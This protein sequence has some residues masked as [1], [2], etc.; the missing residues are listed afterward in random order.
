MTLNGAGRGCNEFHVLFLVDVLFLVKSDSW[1]VG[2]FVVRP[3]AGCNID[4]FQHCKAFQGRCFLLSSS[5]SATQAAVQHKVSQPLVALCCQYGSPV[6]CNWLLCVLLCCATETTPPHTSCRNG[7]VPSRSVRAG[8]K[9]SFLRGSCAHCCMLHMLHGFLVAATARRFAGGTGMPGLIMLCCILL[10]TGHYFGS[11]RSL[12]H[13]PVFFLLQ[14]L[15]TYS[16]LEPLP[17]RAVLHECAG[18]A[19]RPMPTR[20]STLLGARRGT[21]GG[22]TVLLPLAFDRASSFIVMG[23]VW[24]KT[25]LLWGLYGGRQK[26]NTVQCDAQ[27]RSA[28]A[29]WAVKIYGIL[30][31]GASFFFIAW[32]A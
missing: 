21:N 1:T 15:D 9:I 29:C 26:D 11:S 7:H 6:S 19:P 5:S 2:D 32:S 8:V 17:E 31:V 14:H 30:L 12:G 20:L 3:V 27:W 10:V 24:G 18:A 16:H 13:V 25:S 23:V 28:A 22:A 4:C